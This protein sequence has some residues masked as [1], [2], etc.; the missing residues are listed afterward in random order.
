MVDKFENSKGIMRNR[1]QK[2]NRQ[3]NG[4]NKGLKGQTMIYKAQ[5]LKNQHELHKNWAKIMCS[6]VKKVISFDNSNY[7]IG[8]FAKAST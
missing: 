6:A 4:P 3:H 7:K 1:K 8:L 5:K 2:K